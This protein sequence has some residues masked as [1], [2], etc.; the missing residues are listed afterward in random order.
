MPVELP[1]HVR[2]CR[3]PG[4]MTDR[5]YDGLFRPIPDAPSKKSVGTEKD[6]FPNFLKP[7][8]RMGLLSNSIP[9][10]EKH[11]DLNWTPSWKKFVPAFVNPPA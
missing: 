3:L 1:D 5:N 11:F 2:S 6:S 4:L 10:V 9:L 7:S 8:N